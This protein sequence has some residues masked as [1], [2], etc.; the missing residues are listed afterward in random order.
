MCVAGGDV[1][2]TLGSPASRD[3]MQ[4]LPIDLL[5]VVVDNLNFVAVAHVV[6]RRGWWRGSLVAIM[7]ADHIGDWIVA[8]R[9]HMNDGQFDVI[10]VSASMSIRQR[11]IAKGRLS[12][13]THVPHPAVSA[14][15]ART[16]TWEFQ[17]PM[18]VW[19]DGVARGR[20]NRLTVTIEADAFALYV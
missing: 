20:V 14:R 13:G 9:G 11:F 2:R 4:C 10:E 1:F 8:P 15:T 7:N 18:N 19:I 5:H 17:K 3:A 12:T 6:V 16:Q